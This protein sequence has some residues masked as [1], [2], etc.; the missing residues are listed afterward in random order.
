MP[1]SRLKAASTNLIPNARAP[2]SHQCLSLSLLLG[3]GCR[4]AVSLY[5]CSVP[6]AP[7]SA[8]R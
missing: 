4:V 2:N 6:A 1:T 5:S 7:L 3:D 8:G